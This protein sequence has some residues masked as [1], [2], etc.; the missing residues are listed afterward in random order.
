MSQKDTI[1]K[2]TFD[3]NKKIIIG[4]V[5]VLVGITLIY[6]TRPFLDDSQFSIIAIP[7][8][9]LFPGVVTAYAAI[10][11]IKL[12]KQKNFE[13]KGYLMFAIA[14]SILVCC[15]TNLAII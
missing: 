5:L 3:N 4:L 10:L 15:R 14:G 11:A 9:A 1:L 13:S 2:T 6:Q 8:Y 12:H 7:A